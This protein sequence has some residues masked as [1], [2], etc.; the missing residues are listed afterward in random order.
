VK[1]RAAAD[2]RCM[3]SLTSDMLT[4]PVQETESTHIY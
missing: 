4:S 1:G 2:V 3:A